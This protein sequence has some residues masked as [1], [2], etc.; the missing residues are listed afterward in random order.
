[1]PLTQTPYADTLT[2]ADLKNK[3]NG[4]VIYVC[5]EAVNGDEQ[6]TDSVDI[7]LFTLSSCGGLRRIEVPDHMAQFRC[8]DYDRPTFRIFWEGDTSTENGIDFFEARLDEEAKSADAVSCATLLV[9]YLAMTAKG[10][11]DFF[12]IKFL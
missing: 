11:P 12:T 4:D 6:F 5:C 10:R 1:M 9:R 7:S 8:A 2:Y 3:H